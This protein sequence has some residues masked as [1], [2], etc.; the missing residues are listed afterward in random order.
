MA[1]LNASG[2]RLR[3]GFQDFLVEKA[4]KRNTVTARGIMEVMWALA[5]DRAVSAE[6][7]KE[8]MSLIVNSRTATSGPFAANQG[9]T[10]TGK[11]FEQPVVVYGARSFALGVEI[12]GPIS[13]S[14]GAALISKISHA[15]TATN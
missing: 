13:G 11:R 9:G 5:T 12:Q 2:I 7:S 3:H 15:L 4:G 1:D 10:A 6:A 8:T 14:A